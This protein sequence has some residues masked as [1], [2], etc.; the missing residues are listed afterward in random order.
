MRGEE[1]STNDWKKMEKERKTLDGGGDIGM[2]K[3]DLQN[4]CK[5]FKG[6]RER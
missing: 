2:R 4:I 6:E 3:N 5:M 1:R